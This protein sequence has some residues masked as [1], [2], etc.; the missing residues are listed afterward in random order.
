VKIRP[1]PEIDLARIAPL[2]SDMKRR[3]LGV[4]RLGR[5][6]YSYRPMRN[7][8]SDIL[9]IEAGVFE[10]PRV[11]WD[12]VA[13]AIARQSR[14]EDEEQANLQTAEGLYRFAEAR[15]LRGRKQDF[16]PLAVGVGYSVSYWHSVV[17]IE[18]GHPLVPFFDP[19]RSRRLTPDARRFVF[20]MMHERIRVA[21]PDFA[22]VRLGIFQFSRA[23]DGPRRPQLYTD[24]DVVP[25]SFDE[26]DEMV[27]ETYTVWQEVSEEREEEARHTAS[28]RR[29]G[30]L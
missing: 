2:P 26:L 5:P 11:P 4:F 25:F 14:S 17:L 29:G 13:E 30:L 3:E 15:D 16:L 22:G 8:L 27:R 18:D 10:L 28:G 7:T 6:P 21:D 9:N 24:E 1:L 20:S 12:R 19:R 23:N